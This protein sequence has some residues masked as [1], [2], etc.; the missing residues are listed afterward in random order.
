MHKKNALPA[1]LNPRQGVQLWRSL[2]TTT[3][4]DSALKGCVFNIQHYSLHD[5]PGIRT[6]VFLKGCPLRCE[7]CCNPESQRL[8]PELAYNPKKCIGTE[9]CFRCKDVCQQNAIGL[10]EDSK[11]TINREICNLCFACVDSCPS[12]AMHVFGQYMSVGEVLKIVEADSVFY[13]RSGG[14]LTISGGEPLMQPEFTLALLREARRLHIDST[15]ETCGFADWA[16]LKEVG[17]HLKLILFDIKSMNNTKH[18]TV[19]GV[20][21]ELI[22]GNFRKLRDAF[23]KLQILARIP[24]IPGLNDTEEEIGAILSFIKIMKNVS[25][26]LLPYHRI[27][28]SKYKFLG[29]EYCMAGVKLSDEK[30]QLLQ[31]YVRANYAGE[32]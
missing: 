20:S 2:M 25:C 23:P 15:V 30:A 5:G 32:N 27:G 16:I 13:A 28:Q 18:K 4:A 21:N 7:W 10:A 6:I 9:E 1:A 24:L 8:S 29:R 26:E 31:D 22:L 17:R 19:T 11:I 12:R 3:Q 14:G